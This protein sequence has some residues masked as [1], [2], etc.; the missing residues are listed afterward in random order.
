LKPE[1]GPAQLAWGE[2][3]PGAEDV[4]GFGQDRTLVGDEG[5]YREG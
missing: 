1:R 4:S 2:P 3:L 5:A